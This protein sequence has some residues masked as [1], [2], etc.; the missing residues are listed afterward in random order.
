M[1][2]PVQP[3]PAGHAARGGE[4]ARDAEPPRPA[5][6]HAHGEREGAAREAGDDAE[7]H[8]IHAELA[9]EDRQVQTIEPERID[10]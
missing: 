2:L 9:R 8:L 5:D 10:L 3:L 1:Q 6:A 7:V 4:F